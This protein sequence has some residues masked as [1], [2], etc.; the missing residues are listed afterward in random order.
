LHAAKIAPKK[1]GNKIDVTTPLRA[2]EVSR[3]EFIE[4][5]RQS[6]EFNCVIESILAEAKRV[7]PAAEKYGNRI[8]A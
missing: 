8:M 6:S 2:P 1:Y 7:F 4:Y 5:L 3:E